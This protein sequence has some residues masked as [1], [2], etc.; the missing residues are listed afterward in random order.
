[1]NQRIYRLFSGLVLSL[2]LLIPPGI[3]A[4]SSAA[5]MAAE[6]ADIDDTSTGELGVYIHHLG[7]GTKVTYNAEQLWYLASTIK[8]PVAI[9]VLQRVEEG[10]WSLTDEL[11]LRQSD[12]VDGSG[13]LLWQEPGTRYTLATL[14][15]KSITNSDS[16]ATDMLIRHLGVEAFNQQL[17]RMVPEGFNHLTTIL[18]V[19]YDAYAELHPNAS[20]LS[21]MDYVHIRSAGNRDNRV[22]EFARRLKIDNAQLRTSDLDEAFE[23]YYVSRRNTATLKAY[24]TLLERLAN[25]ELLNREHTE[26]LLSH[27]QQ[28]STGADRLKA[29]LPNGVAFAQKTGT[30]IERACNVGIVQPHHPS[31]AIVIVACTRHF[32]SLGNAEETFQRVAK[33]LNQAGWL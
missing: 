31:N 8:V 19:R 32:G 9:A 13:D 3:Q 14:I 11:T 33:E 22:A 1:M 15:E 6:I 21:N 7:T 4:Q 23:R 16:T 2:A 24:G 25:G 29:G 10:R 27:M 30:Q 18:Q 17:R 26:L 20:Q 12:F 28:I 5:F